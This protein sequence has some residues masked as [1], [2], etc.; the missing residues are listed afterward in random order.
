MS[1]SSV[2]YETALRYRLCCTGHPECRTHSL[3][4]VSGRVSAKSM[5]R[6]TSTG[7]S[8]TPSRRTSARIP[9]RLIPAGIW[10]LRARHWVR[11][12]PGCSPSSPAT[13][14]PPPYPPRASPPPPPLN[15]AACSANRSPAPLRAPHHRYTASP[16]HATPS[17]PT[18]NGCHNMAPPHLTKTERLSALLNLLAE[19]GRLDV[20]EVV[21]RLGVSPATARR[22]LDTLARQQLLRRTRGGAIAHSVAYELPLRYENQQHLEPKHAI[23]QAASALIPRGAIIGLGGGNTTTAIA[24]ELLSRA[25]IMEPSAERGLTVVTNAINIAMLLAPRPQI[26]TVVVGGVINPRSYE[27]T[28]PLTEVVLRGITLDVAFVGVNG[29]HPQLGPTSHDEREAAVDSAMAA[30]ARTAVLVADSTKM[31]KTAFAAIGRGGFFSTLI[32]DAAVT[33]PQR[34]ACESLGYT[35]IVAS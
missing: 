10:P 8:Q 4:E 2:G 9:Q 5:S 7:F 27:L 35:V 25:D 24:H 6:R 1:I 22:D 34:T 13:N 15:G 19:T 20:D 3:C 21:V 29:I 11:K 32:R 30:R 23:A 26:K 18:I 28:G 31:D 16:V 33:A 12:R 14:P 17:A